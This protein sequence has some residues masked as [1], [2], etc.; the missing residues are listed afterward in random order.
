AKLSPDGKLIA[1]SVE[2]NGRTNV[3]LLDADTKKAL[4]S[5]AVG[6]DRYQL[7]WFR[8]AGNGRILFSI[9]GT[10]TIEGDEYRYTRLFVSD[11]TTHATTYVGMSNEGLVG[12]DVLYVAPDGAYVLLA[13]QD[14]VTDPPEVRR[15]ALDGTAKNG[16][17]VLDRRSDVWDWLADDK[18]V[19][20]VGFSVAG[21]QVGVLYRKSESEPFK[22]IARLSGDEDADHSQLYAAT[23]II[24]GSDDGLTLDKGPSGKIA[25]RHVNLA[26]GKVGDVVYENS[27]WDVTDFSLTDDGKPLAAFYTDDR[28]K[29][30][31]LDP[32]M[33]KVQAAL[34]KALG[35]AQVWITSRD[36]DD[37]RMIVW[38]GNSNDPGA[39]YLYTA[40]KHTLDL[41]T[42]VRPGLPPAA[43]APVK[44]VTY[45]ARDGTPIHAYLTLPK[46]REPRNLPLIIMPHGGPYDVRDTLDYNDEV[47]FLANRGYAVLQPNYRGSGGYGDAFEKLGDGQIGRTMQDD[48]DDAEDWAVKQG[49]ADK[50]RVCVDGSSYGGYAALWAVIRNPERYRCAASFAGVTDWAKQ[51]HYDRNFFTRSGNKEWQARVRGTDKAF[52]MQSV[53]PAKQAARLTRPVLIAQGKRDSNVPFSQ[54]KEMQ[55]ALTEAKF[56]KA[57]YL[58]FDKEG[59]GFDTAEDEQKWYDALDAFLKKNNPAD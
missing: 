10:T 9:S 27:D 44:P 55:S 16:Q 36:N 35:G 2:A 14:A 33:A 8:W 3:V 21:S 54:F 48:L 13:Q 59:H 57:D 11:L 56:D 37:S 28:D 45:T 17:K 6:D 1:L 24:G 22:T 42:D 7:E 52:D 53:S 40:G 50:A 51:L 15:F 38:S 49:I 20:R 41:L 23:K 34:E 30:V 18:G 25:L 46:D 5:T 26:T 43:L 29:I 4:T 47:Q 58:V 39:Y 32:A 31:W 12:D 19:V